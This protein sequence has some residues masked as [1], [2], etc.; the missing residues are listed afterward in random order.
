[1]VANRGR[2]TQSQVQDF[3]AA[4]YSKAQ[5]LEVIT[6]VAVKTIS[7]Y[8]NHFADTPLDNALESQRWTPPGD[9]TG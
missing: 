9:W 2:L 3:V 8:T 5:V 6:A 1:M 7:N 4:G